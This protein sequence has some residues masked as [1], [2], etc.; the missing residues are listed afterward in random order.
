MYVCESW[1]IKNRDEMHT[2]DSKGIMHTEEANEWVLET[3]RVKRGLLNI[4]KRR[5]LLWTS[6]EKMRLS[7]ERNHARH[8]TGSKKT[9]ETKDAMDGQHGR[10]DRNAV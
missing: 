6:D 4:I 2:K 9:R 3:A 8:Y 7:G 5:K 1:T 10:M